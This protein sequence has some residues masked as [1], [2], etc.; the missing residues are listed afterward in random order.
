MQ[1]KTIRVLGA[2]LGLGC[3]F[4]SSPA[5][6]EQPVTIPLYFGGI[7]TESYTANPVTNL[8]ADGPGSSTVDPVD[9]NQAKAELTGNTLI[10]Q[11]HV[12]GNVE[13]MISN[14][15]NGETILYTRFDDSLTIQLT[16]TANY[17]L[18]MR[19]EDGRV[20]YGLFSYPPFINGKEVKNGQ[21]Y[22]R[23]GY[24]I[25]ALPGTKVK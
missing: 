19:F 6:A 15:D 1:A 23:H 5:R 7:N 11:E 3:L 2:L 10:V 16:D 21:L 17:L 20:A 12:N 8:A 14:Y 25:Y 22:I 13:I 24:S 9:P 4:A 18:R